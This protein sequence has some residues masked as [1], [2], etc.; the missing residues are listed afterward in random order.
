MLYLI[1][2]PI[3]NLGDI[4]YRAVETLQSCNEIWCEDTRQTVKLLNHLNIKKPL[5]SCHEYTQKE[6]APQL[7]EKLRAG[8]DVAY[9][10]DAGMPGI[11]DPG[12]VLVRSCI[13][14]GLPYTVLP[15]SSAVLTAAVL[16][17]LPLD[18]F[19][20]FGFLPR[21]GMERKKALH[22]LASYGAT[23]I[24]YESPHRV[25]DTLRDVLDVAGDC[26]C[27]LVRELTKVHESCQRGLISEVLWALPDEVRG[28]CV[29]LFSV[30]PKQEEAPSKEDLDGL[31]LRLMDHMTLKDAAREASEAL[32]LPKKQ[33]YARALELKNE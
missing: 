24:L 20:F 18:R 11:S 7:M 2:T 16:S 13:E 28:E 8:M 10:S 9:V 27:A 15:G 22:D 31:L 21:E 3:G 25:K 5:V 12:A 4:T 30:P 33:V 23:V 26:P 1:A 14:A 6:K 19:A 32:K 17:G 29:L